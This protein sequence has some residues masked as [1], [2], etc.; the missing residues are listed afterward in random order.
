MKCT[1]IILCCIEK[2]SDVRTDSY[3]SVPHPNVCMPGHSALPTDDGRVRERCDVRTGRRGSHSG[4]C[5]QI[6][7][8]QE[9][10]DIPAVPSGSLSLSLTRL[11]VSAAAHT[12]RSV[13][14]ASRILQRLSSTSESK[15]QA[16]Q[17]VMQLV[18]SQYS[19]ATDHTYA[20]FARI[21]NRLAEKIYL[22]AGE[23]TAT[24]ALRDAGQS[25]KEVCQH[26]RST[27]KTA[28][29]SFDQTQSMQT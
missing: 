19:V 1:S 17:T 27:F 24:E 21:E 23:I 4:K 5:A 22:S 11:R 3:H 16:R 13:G 9:V 25:L 7:P 2:A 12:Y 20:L 15:P 28:N 26:V 8:E 10:R 18:L 29:E 14:I 6:F